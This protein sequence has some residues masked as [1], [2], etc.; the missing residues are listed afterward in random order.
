MTISLPYVFSILAGYL[1]V[2]TALRNTPKVSFFLKLF[3]AIGAGLGLSSLIT[4]LSFLFCNG[5]NRSF[6]VFANLSCIFFLL[7]I[8]SKQLKEVLS[9]HAVRFD[10]WQFFYGIFLLLLVPFI[11]IRANEH[12][13][14]EWDSW[15][16]WNMKAKFLT[17]SGP[18]WQSVF[19]DLHWHTQ[20]D[21]PLLLPCMN[22]WGWIFTP[23]DFFSAPFLTAALFA[24]ACAGL[25]FAGLL[26]FTDRKIAFLGCALL[27]ALPAY[28]PLA[29]SQY[30]D[31]VLA[32]YLLAGFISFVGA[33]QEKSKGFGFLF[34]FFLGLMSFTKNEGL[35][36]AFILAV[37]CISY[38]LFEKTAGRQANSSVIRLIFCGL[39]ITLPVSIYFKLC[40]APPNHD[41]LLSAAPRMSSFFNLEGC[42]IIFENIALQL[43]HPRWY[44]LWPLVFCGFLLDWRRYFKKEIRALFLFLILYVL[45][46]FFIYL[47]TINFSLAWRLSRTLSRILFYLSPAVIFLMF[48]VYASGKSAPEKK[49]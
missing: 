11:L 32:Y 8:N 17:L 48:Y 31:I 22:I 7:I 40:L 36:M 38:F 23:G 9:G 33:V 45:V 24:F 43:S 13:L 14:G 16:L 15:A 29:T 20:P 21:Y 46:I 5:Y 12:P 3:L 4:F 19:K 1:L 18:L 6:I 10:P 28:L 47:T 27:F 39:I 25:L 49:L 30:A 35:T 44:H 42:S 41:I 2:E 26:Q 37:L 34:G